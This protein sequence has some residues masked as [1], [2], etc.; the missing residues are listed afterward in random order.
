MPS[1]PPLSGAATPPTS[2]AEL[3]ERAHA[4]AGSTI[5]ELAAELGV[6]RE[7]VPHSQLHAKGFVGALIEKLLGAS[8]TSKALPDFPELGI[9]LKTIPVRRDGR[10][11]E[12]TFVCTIELA[13]IADSEW[14]T[15]RVRTKLAEVLWVPIEA[16]PKVQLPERRVGTPF[17]WKL[18]EA[19]EATLRADWEELASLVGRGQTELITAHLGVA[20]Q[21]RPKARDASARRRAF[22]EDGIAYRE[23]PR[24]F[25]LRSTFTEA[26]I[27]RQ[28][29]RRSRAQTNAP[30]MPNE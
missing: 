24:G 26:I 20:L 6:L 16:D 22:D 4:L 25:Y 23:L 27:A 14:E 19:D 15:S 8:A 12:S 11:R 30:R 17:L 7:Q 28:F 21:V 9:E 18:E 29:G 13:D 2:R 10:P 5:S 3:L 1:L